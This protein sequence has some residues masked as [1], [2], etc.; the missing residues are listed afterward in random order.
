MMLSGSESPETGST[1][2]F[3]S[4][5]LRPLMM[6]GPVMALDAKYHGLDSVN[7]NSSH[8]KVSDEFAASTHCLS[9]KENAEL[10][11]DRSLFF[12]TFNSPAW[13]KKSVGSSSVT[14]KLVAKFAL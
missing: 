11:L 13:K 12:P 14:M 2:P 5:I 1:V 9:R 7:F 10:A 4:K 3:W 6:Y 8:S